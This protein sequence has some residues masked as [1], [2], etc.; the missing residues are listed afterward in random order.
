MFL[1]N[2]YLCS[3]APCKGKE[4]APQENKDC[5]DYTTLS[6]AGLHRPEAWNKLDL[7]WKQTCRRQDTKIQ[8]KWKPW[9]RTVLPTVTLKT[10]NTKLHS[11][12][13]KQPHTCFIM[14]MPVSSPLLPSPLSHSWGEMFVIK[15]ALSQF[16]F[17][18]TGHKFA[19]ECSKIVYTLSKG[20]TLRKSQGN[21]G[22]SVL[23]KIIH[24]KLF[25]RL[26]P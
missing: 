21:H 19:Q 22:I 17:R 11:F 16:K 7:N 15:W 12:L 1:H 4:I 26:W 23:P 9:S 14:V 3:Q 13:L 18:K 8:W 10:G 5:S 24:P 20:V 2:G 25:V 6:L